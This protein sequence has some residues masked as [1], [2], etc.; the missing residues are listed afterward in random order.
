MQREA[1][2][3][4][5]L[6]WEEPK[7]KIL[8]VPEK[9]NE[10]G[11][12]AREQLLPG[13]ELGDYIG[14]LLG[15]DEVR[16]LPKD[17]GF[18]LEV[19]E[20]S[21]LYVDPIDPVTGNAKYDTQPSHH[22]HSETQTDR[23]TLRRAVERAVEKIAGQR[24]SELACVACL[25]AARVQSGVLSERAVCCKVLLPGALPKRAVPGTGQSELVLTHL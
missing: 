4:M 6:G 12:F 9:G 17:T 23:Q 13:T 3:E 20:D 10:L 15:S 1:L 22:I 25:L 18:R 21:G 7:I 14:Q 2:T 16:K 5:L 11:V 24:H 8:R 19:A